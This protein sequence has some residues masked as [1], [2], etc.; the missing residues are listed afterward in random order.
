MIINDYC[1]G[2]CTK[3]EGALVTNEVQSPK[4]VL[5]FGL[6]GLGYEAIAVGRFRSL[7][8]VVIFGAR[9]GP[10]SA[11]HVGV[12]VLTYGVSLGSKINLMKTIHFLHQRLI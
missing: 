2:E 3:A 7:D 5:Q 6:T 12:L 8:T 10:C 9:F 4:S 1:V 11:G